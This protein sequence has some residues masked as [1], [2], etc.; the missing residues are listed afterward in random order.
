MNPYCRFHRGPAQGFTLVELLVVMF[1]VSVLIGLLLPAVQAVRQAAVRTQCANN[2]RQIGL[3]MHLYM[4]ANEGDFPWTIHAGE[5]LSWVET[6]KPFSESVN[7]VRLCQ[8]DPLAHVWSEQ[9]DRGT[10]YVINE[11]V[12][13]ESID[14]AVVN[15]NHIKS[16]H[17]LIVLFEGGSERTLN[18]EHVH[19]SQFYTP[20]RIATDTVWVLLQ[21]E[22][23]TSRH[24]NS[25]NYLY[26]DGHVSTV[27]EDT[28]LE[29]TQRD[30]ENETN[31]A[32]PF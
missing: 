19:C 30:I 29:W 21:R 20:L 22:V 24:F 6:L 12:A 14:G 16:T 25:S 8:N 7:E 18:E 3:A 11:Y 10:S 5:N 13:N 31:F 26:A 17:S 2:M 32:L 9:I 15:I 27:A 4:G 1:I 28:I 23:D